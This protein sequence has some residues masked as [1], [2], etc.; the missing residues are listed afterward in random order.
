MNV[1]F[2]IL[3]LFLEAPLADGLS[4]KN[5]RGKYIFF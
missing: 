5:I 3:L 1:V 4:E 2:N